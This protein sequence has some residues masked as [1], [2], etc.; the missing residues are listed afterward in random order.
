MARPSLDEIF[1]S[2]GAR[3]SL[4]QIFAGQAP[5]PVPAAP[6]SLRRPTLD[7]I[8]GEPAA[9]E[10]G[11]L[12]GESLLQTPT[13]SMPP[14]RAPASFT[15]LGTPRPAAPTSAPQP[16]RYTGL[17][18]AQPPGLTA[19]DVSAALARLRMDDE[20]LAG[21]LDAQRPDAVL[22]VRLLEQ[23]ERDNALVEK[24]LQRRPP[25]A[26]PPVQPPPAPGDL[27][28]TESPIDATRTPPLPLPETFRPSPRL[29]ESGGANLL[30]VPRLERGKPTLGDEAEAFGK[31]L[32]AGASAGLYEPDPDLVGGSELTAVAGRLAGAIV[33]TAAA[34]AAT[35][36]AGAAAASG[37]AL[38]MATQ[39]LTDL[40]RRGVPVSRLG[41]TD[42][43]A[44]AVASGFVGA[45]TP[46]SVGGRTSTRLASAAGLGVGQN[47]AEESIIAAISDSPPEYLDAALMGGAMA[48]TLVLTPGLYR[49]IRGALGDS[50]A[51]GIAAE[52]MRNAGKKGLADLQAKAPEWLDKARYSPEELAARGAESPEPA[53]PSPAPAAAA[54][55]PEPASP[56]AP[57]RVKPATVEIPPAPETPNVAA[58]RK[59]GVTDEQIN[60]LRQVPA[61]RQM[62]DEGGVPDLPVRIEGGAQPPRP[63]TPPEKTRTGHEDARYISAADWLDSQLSTPPTGFPARK[64]T[65]YVHPDDLKTLGLQGTEASGRGFKASEARK[66]YGVQVVVTPRAQRIGR[67]AHALNEMLTEGHRGGTN[68]LATGRT[69]VWD[70]D[71]IDPDYGLTSDDLVTAL[72]NRSRKPADRTRDLEDFKR[73]TSGAKAEERLLDEAAWFESLPPADQEAWMKEHQAR[74]AEAASRTPMDQND[75]LY[76]QPPAPAF[77]AGIPEG[78]RASLAVARKA[79]ALWREKGTESPFFRKW[80]GDSKV[81]DESGKPLVAYHG[82]TADFKAFSNDFLGENTGSPDW[83]EGFYFSDK[84]EVAGSFAGGDGANIMPVHLKIKNP[85]DAAVMRR[86]EVQDA[87]H[88]DMGFTSVKD[89]LEKMGYDGIVIDHPNGGGREY[90]VFNPEQVKS[91]TGNRGTFDARSPNIL[92]QRRGEG[93]RGSFEL[94]DLPGGARGAVIKLFE[95]RAD[96]STFIHEAGHYLRRAA[97]TGVDQAAVE[98]WLIRDG[99]MGKDRRWTVK[100]EEAFASALERYFWEGKAPSDGVRRAFAKIKKWMRQ[101][102]E[103][104][105]AGSRL[106]VK[107][108]PEVRATFDRI[109]GLGKESNAAEA[110]PRAEGE[111][112]APDTE[113]PTQG[114]LFQPTRQEAKRMLLDAWSKVLGTEGKHA[115]SNINIERLTRW[116]SERLLAGGLKRD[117]K[118]WQVWAPVDYNQ[119][120]DH[121]WRNH[122]KD[123]KAERDRAQIPLSAKDIARLPEVV[124][125]PNQAW[126]LPN[127]DGRGNFNLELDKY[128]EDG[129]LVT[130]WGIY[131][132]QK[133]IRLTTMWKVPLGGGVWRRGELI[134]LAREEAEKIHGT[135]ASPPSHLGAGRVETAGDQNTTSENVPRRVLKGKL[136]PKGPKLFQG[137]VDPQDEAF[138][139]RLQDEAAGEGDS[140]PEDALEASPGPRWEPAAPEERKRR[141][142]ALRAEMRAEEEK[143]MAAIPPGEHRA[144]MDKL[145]AE[146]ISY[147]ADPGES[148]SGFLTLAEKAYTDYVNEAYPLEKVQTLAE[149]ALGGPLKPGESIRFAVDRVLGAGGAAN[150]YIDENLKPIT[151]GGEMGGVKYAAL[152]PDD[153]RWLDQ[154]TIARDVLWR[155]DNVDSFTGG[156]MA[157]EEAEGILKRHYALPPQQRIRIETAANGLVAYAKKLAARLVEMRVWTDEELQQITRN[158]FYVPLLRDWAKVRATPDNGARKRSFTSTDKMTRGHYDP[159]LEAPWKDP[160]SALVSET[161]RQAAEIAK[162]AVWNRVVDAVEKTPDLEQWIKR[163]PK[164]T[165]LKEAE[166]RAGTAGGVVSVLRPRQLQIDPE[167]EKFAKIYGKAKTNLEE[168]KALETVERD[169]GRY[170]EWQRQLQERIYREVGKKKLTR[171]QAEAVDNAIAGQERRR[172]EWLKKRHERDG[173]IV[174]KFEALPADKRNLI[175]DWL[176]EGKPTL[177]IVPRE[178]SD[179]VNGMAPMEWAWFAKPF[180]ASAS[181]FRRMQVG[182]NP[183]FSG[184]NVPRDLQEAYFTTGL[185]PWHAFSGFWHYIKDTELA[186]DYHRWG[187]GMEGDESGFQAAHDRAQELRYKSDYE[188]LRD[189]AAWEERKKTDAGEELTKRKLARLAFGAGI[190]LRAAAHAMEAIGE[191]GEMMSRLGMFEAA[192]KKGLTKAEA[193]RIARQGTLDFRRIGAKMRRANSLIPFLNARIQGLDRMTR[194]AKDDPVGSGVRALLVAGVPAIAT[195]AWNQQ[196]PNY[197]DIPSWEK[198][199]YWILMMDKTGPGY[200]K[201]A[202]G[203]LAQMLVNPLQMMMENWLGT[204]KVGGW[205]IAADIIGGVSPIQDATGFLP[206]VAQELVEQTANF[207]TYFSRDIVRDPSL[208]AGYQANRGTSETLRALGAALSALPDGGYRSP[209]RIQHAIQGLLGGTGTNILFALDELLGKTGAIPDRKTRVEQVPL[210]NRFWSQAREWKSDFELEKRKIERRRRE[211]RG[212]I[213]GGA[214]K[215]F[216]RQYGQA[217]GEGESE[218]YLRQLEAYIDSGIAAV[219]KLQEEMQQRLDELPAVENG[220]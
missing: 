170:R 164:G 18:G 161:H 41:E 198:E 206:P 36:G 166:D 168:G 27:E 101:V 157:R 55:V 24:W 199:Y 104:I 114:P 56:T 209:E 29:E 3:P 214:I 81:V 144:A 22:G 169:E 112:R 171:Q 186:K 191:A 77:M 94:E 200:F 44:L 9:P 15:G 204:G 19:D 201:I 1:A 208:P 187:G 125:A 72:Q 136:K 8:F 190:P 54:P 69:V 160:V 174:K 73:K 53:G 219:N 127:K 153:M 46:L 87:L 23:R 84:P 59:A 116:A 202:K 212:G 49:A 124:T 42:I 16:Q 220:H 71:R 218:E 181:L 115:E 74:N 102:Y 26:E 175:E 113:D 194:A 89:V 20:A 215:R 5:E 105:R 106:D 97:L 195:L 179:I 148:R 137:D 133:E 128:F 217:E 65:F 189:A 150:L 184:A 163:V 154:F 180:V 37:P 196:N 118:G 158:P 123:A 51:A 134:P 86:P 107:I 28:P 98:G 67:A 64:R 203:H 88:D 141:A 205:S 66:V 38:F 109:L 177:Y 108:P 75:D 172:Q 100:A 140:S 34:G 14:P 176:A 11:R 6:R 143:R 120:I 2:S 62:L 13:R 138:M 31:N 57:P 117:V 122:S 193:V 17:G 131:P 48:G 146:A 83:G 35:G 183:A 156:T 4:D 40:H 85:A 173:A 32:A 60:T 135:Q 68:D 99:A 70:V 78:K 178:V 162:M 197:A 145:A 159:G 76:W 79:A 52:A 92:E 96:I 152:S 216:R 155:Y 121:A 207:D 103:K 30:P 126:A 45:L 58:M 90:V 129:W 39:F 82:T 21:V 7:E 95:G 167:L 165:G 213:D 110:A 10:P 25:S 210:L 211:L 182:W 111:V 43:L 80:F 61:F 130:R 185:K 91:A 132:K 149:K 63:A 188:K 151:R 33:G 142:D 119:G 93:A 192:L 47:V 50:R 147:D 12:E 139:R